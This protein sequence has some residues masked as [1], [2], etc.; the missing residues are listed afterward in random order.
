MEYIDGEPL[1]DGIRRRAPWSLQRKLQM[2][3]DLCSGLAFAHRAGVVHR[4]VKPSNLIVSN[5]SGTL[6][7]LDFGIARGADPRQSWASRCTATS[8]GR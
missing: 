7:L 4:D 5:G 1:S 3:V 6:R 8:S 2:A